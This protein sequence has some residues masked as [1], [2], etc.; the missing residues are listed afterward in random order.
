VGAVK[1]TAEKSSTASATRTEALRQPFVA[2]AGGGDFFPRVQAKMTVGKPGDKFE[3]EAG[4]TADNVMRMPAPQAAGAEKVQRQPEDK[5]QRRREEKIFRAA[6]PDDIQKAAA[7]EQKIQRRQEEKIFRAADDKIQKAQEEKTQKAG[8]SPLRAEER[9]LRA[10]DDKVQK[11]DDHHLQK[12]PAEGE[13]LQRDAAACGGGA[14]TVSGNVQSAIHG[15]STGGEP[16]T[17]DVRG[18]MEPRFG[19][20]FSDVRIHHDA[21]SASLNNQLSARAFTYQ[22]HIFFSRDQYQPGTSKGKHLLAHELTHTIQQ[23]YSVQMSPQI[24]TTASTP[25]IQ[26]LGIQDAL[27]KFAEWA[28]NI[29]GFRMLTFVLG[30]NPVNMRSTD[31]N[32]ANLLRA[33]IELLPGGAFITQALDNHGV[34]NKAAAW[35]EAKL[36]EL[37]DIGG[38]IVDGLKR[39]LDSLSWTDIF[40]LGGVWD[41]AK[42]IF[43]RPIGRLID[44]GISVAIEILKM[45]KDA[46]LKPLATLARGTRG[47]DLLCAILGED[48]ISGEPVPRTAETLLGGFMKLI[49]Q[50]EIWENIKKGN[51][52]ARAW[53]WFQGALDG[54]MGFVRTVPRKIIDTLTSLT[55]QDV[56]TVAGAFTKVV[57]TFAN[58]AVDF[59]SWGLSTIW[60]LLKIIFDVVKPGLMGYIQRTGAAL[61]S[62]LKNPMP[63]LGN[64]ARAAKTG[65]TNFA[66]HIVEHLKNGLIDWLTGSLEGVYIPKALSLIELGKFVLSVLGLAWAQI[67]GKIVT[68]LGP[69]GEKIMQALET[70]FDVVVALVKGGI[71][72]VWDLIK[73]KLADLK[74]QVMNG[75]I[76]FVVETIVKKAIPKLIGMFIPGAGFIPAV[77]SIYDTIMVF[78]EKIAKII[79]VVMAFIDSI[80]TIAAGNIGAAAKRVESVLAGLLSLAI[81]FLAGFLGLG[82]V[83]DKIKEVIQKVREKVDA[84]IGAAANWIVA[85]AKALFARLFGDKKDDDERS[86]KVKAAATADIKA[87][88]HTMSSPEELDAMVGRVYDKHAK[89]GLNSIRVVS[90]GEGR[91]SIVLNASADLIADEVCFLFAATNP[92]KVIAKVTINNSWVEERTYQN[93]DGVHAEEVIVVDWPNILSR[94][95]AANK[96]MPMRSVDVF[97]KYSPCK[98]KCA[99]QLMGI[100]AQHPNTKFTV[101]Y[102]ELY[103]GKGGKELEN[104]VD[105][106]KTMQRSGIKIAAFELSAKL[107]QI[108]RGSR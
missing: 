78:V 3:Q 94:F 37:G 61:K 16:L 74:D 32:A 67:R 11:G 45:V 49:G 77:V 38:E 44:F 105:A 35:V 42:R 106:I 43:T 15:R 30:F 89:N 20:D 53:V 50:E 75:I 24:S 17:S 47:Y 14:S 76:S 25:A 64:L 21:E 9:I 29:P 100:A 79:Q 7:D 72:A 91:A 8:L 33:L 36:A 51:A 40:D 4:K 19:A 73:E 108:R 81:S 6:A 70:A 88:P 60:E 66:D 85:K 59:I 98:G 10:P 86:A 22:N 56:V 101:Y 46:I 18:F 26:R 34:I 69:N 2:R 1:A 82:K 12:A 41:R 93:Q 107:A 83:T 55:F 27:D 28:Y 80:V 97:V 52:V 58:I 57:G 39:F 48:P 96:N 62:I 87:A 90:A 103:V 31:R 71:G 68:A 99:P 23:G 54:L 65:F 102:G 13:Q 5:V 95:Q 84:A 104:S 63:F 92:R